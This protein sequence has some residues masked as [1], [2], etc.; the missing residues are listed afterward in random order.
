[1]G[2]RRS[3]VSVSGIEDSRHRDEARDQA[4]QGGADDARSNQ[5]AVGRWFWENRPMLLLMV[6]ILITIGLIGGRRPLRRPRRAPVGGKV[7][8][9]LA[10][11]SSS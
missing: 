1:M 2:C 7:R 9:P 10:S 3:A 5:S 4:P 8:S 6:A 11:S